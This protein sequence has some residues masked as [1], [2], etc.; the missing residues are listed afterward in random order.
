LKLEYKVEKPIL[1]ES[2]HTYTLAGKKIIG[3]NEFLKLNGVGGDFSKI[4]EFILE[5]ARDLGTAVHLTIQ[6]YDEGDLDE[7]TISEPLKPYLEAYK[8]FLADY[9]PEILAIEAAVQFKETIAGTLDKILRIKRR[10]IVLDLK[11]STTL[12]KS[13][14]LQL[15]IYKIEAQYSFGVK[16]HDKWVLQLKKDGTYFV[17]RYDNDFT[18]RKAIKGYLEAY[19]WHKKN[20]RKKRKTKK[21]A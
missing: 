17:K 15:E 20:R 3:A 11:T 1:D 5:R 6:Y 12:H 21:C 16:I 18:D 8:K 14:E 7:S 10:N 4:P 19:G 9:K 2:T 13:T